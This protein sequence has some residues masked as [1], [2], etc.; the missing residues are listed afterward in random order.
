MGKDKER[1]KTRCQTFFINNMM[2]PQRIDN[3]V[4]EDKP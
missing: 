2:A 1:T 3:L 4:C